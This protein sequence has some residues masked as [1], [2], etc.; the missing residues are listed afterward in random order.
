MFGAIMV[1]AAY[2]AC[3]PSI[4]GIITSL[5][6]IIGFIDPAFMV[7]TAS[8]PFVEGTALVQIIGMNLKPLVIGLR[9]SFVAFGYVKATYYFAS[10]SGL[11]YPD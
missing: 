3:W 8:S 2:P 6:F 11:G 1:V 4:V 10:S 5:P 7:G 9:Q